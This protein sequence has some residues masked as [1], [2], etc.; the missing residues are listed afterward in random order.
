MV[1]DKIV[2]SSSSSDFIVPADFSSEWRDITLKQNHSHTQIYTASRY[3]RRFLLKALAP[4]ASG[5]TDYRIQQ[6][7]EFQLAV[8][9]VHPNIAAIYSLEEISGVGRCIVQ[10]WIDGQTLG[11]WLQTKPSKTSRERVL[12]QLMEAME[13]IH[14][15]QLVHR[16]LKSDNI[17]ITRNG[18]NV[19]L[20]DFGLSLTDDT[21]SPLTNDPRKDIIA[22]QQLFPDI[23]PKGSFANIAALRRAINRRKRLIRLLPV[24]LSALLLAAA[25]TL[26]YL[27]WHER[28][29]EQRRFET[30]SEEI[31]M[32][33]AQERAQLEEI[34][35]RRDS[36]S[37]SN[38][39]EMLA[40]QRDM[41]DYSRVTQLFDVKRD[42]IT[43]LYDIDDPLREQFWQMWLHREVDMNNELL[44]IISAKL[45]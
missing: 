23:C 27:S 4:E 38:I 3:G 40:Y 45:K 7:Q 10:E 30:M 8:Q 39:E 24:I 26:F 44:P 18:T 33:I 16:D 15:R 1:N 34:V 25:I 5:L 37:T 17:L 31:D 41:S 11:E 9:L 21:L 32:Y 14:S 42:S 36:Y 2:N 19:K 12:N 28:Q 13:Y 22:L 6:E 35:N 20:I 43:K 29:I